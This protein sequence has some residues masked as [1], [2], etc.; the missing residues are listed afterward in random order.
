MKRLALFLIII[1]I[2]AGC[3]A[4]PRENIQIDS[5]PFPDNY[6]ALIKCYLN[7]QISDSETLEDFVFKKKPER[8]VLHEHFPDIPL[9]KGSEV[10]ES[11]VVYS[12]KKQNGHYVGNDFHVVWIRHN[13]IVAFDY[14]TI[15]LEFR[16]KQRQGDPCASV[17]APD[18]G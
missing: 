17:S 8:V 4:P 13:K 15:P 10:W 5:G 3:A 7:D 1:L 9:R 12:I 16:I 2:L 18:N 11:F 14:K 6:E